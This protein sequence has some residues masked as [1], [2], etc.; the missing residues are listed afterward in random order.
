MKKTS[1]VKESKERQHSNDRRF[2]AMGLFHVVYG[3]LRIP[4]EA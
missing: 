2:G 1:S 4:S 3:W